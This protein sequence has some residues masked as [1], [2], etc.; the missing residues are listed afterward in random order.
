MCAIKPLWLRLALHV[1]LC[2]TRCCIPGCLPPG[3]ATGLLFASRLRPFLWLV[4]CKVVGC[5]CAQI[6]RCDEMARQLRFFTSEVEKAGILVAPRLSADQVGAASSCLPAARPDPACLAA[7]ELDGSF[8]PWRC[9]AAQR[10]APWRCRQERKPCMQ[11]QVAA[12]LADRACACLPA[13]RA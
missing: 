9:C 5:L 10:A 4:R 8:E 13:R 6:K 2:T 3:P 1:D 12:A 7:P 11:G